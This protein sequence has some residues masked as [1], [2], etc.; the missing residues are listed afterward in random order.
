MNSLWPLG[1]LRDAEFCAQAKGEDILPALDVKSA[2]LW[3]R[4]VK[5]L[6]GSVRGRLVR[7]ECRQSKYHSSFMEV[8]CNARDA[9]DQDRF[10]QGAA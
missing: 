6:A 2:D 4:G 3:F 8:G 5:A 1:M 9:E 10:C 7:Q